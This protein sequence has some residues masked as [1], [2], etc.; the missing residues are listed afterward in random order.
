VI[1][2]SFDAVV[3]KGRSIAFELH[4]YTQRL[5][6]VESLPSHESEI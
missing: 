1:Y 2:A 5:A 4:T 6:L 3:W